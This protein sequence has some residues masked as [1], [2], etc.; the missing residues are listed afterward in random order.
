MSLSGRKTAN[1]FATVRVRIGQKIRVGHSIGLIL[2][3]AASRLRHGNKQQAKASRSNVLTAKRWLICILPAVQDLRP[4]MVMCIGPVSD[5]VVN[6]VPK[7]ISSC[8]ANQKLEHFEYQTSNHQKGLLWCIAQGKIDDLPPCAVI[9][10]DAAGLYPLDVLAGPLWLTGIDTKEGIVELL[11][12][13][14]ALEVMNVIQDHDV[15]QVM[16]GLYLSTRNIDNA[17]YETGSI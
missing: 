11:A 16:N 2:K 17:E 5:E 13:E 9:N 12:A 1:F 6:N 8:C 3:R 4:G 14:E 7:F 10:T 15:L